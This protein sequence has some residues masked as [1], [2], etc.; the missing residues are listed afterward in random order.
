MPAQFEN[1]KGN[2]E[3]YLCRLVVHNNDIIL[4]LFQI[5]V[6]CTYFDNNQFPRLHNFALVLIYFYNGVR[7]AKKIIIILTHTSLEI[8]AYAK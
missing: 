7:M 3:Y 5:I 1:V 2:K 8:C 4:N 6:V